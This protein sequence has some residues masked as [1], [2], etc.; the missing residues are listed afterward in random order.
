MIFRFSTIGLLLLFSLPAG[1]A[2]PLK[3]KWSEGEET[4][5]LMTQSMTMS[6]DAGGAG[7]I[8]STTH[9]QML[10]RWRV[11]EVRDEGDALITQSVDRIVMKTN[12]PMGQGFTYDSA[13]EDPPV[14]MGA[15]VA[16]MLDT[17]V[18]SDM[19]LTMAP[20]GEL[21]EVQLSEELAEAFKRVPGGSTSADMLEQMVKKMAFQFPDAPLTEGKSWTKMAT[22]R[23]P[24]MGKLEVETTYTYLGEKVIEGQ[25]LETF[26]VSETLRP[27]GRGQLEMEMTIATRESTGQILF[28]RET[29][30]LVR[31]RITQVM[32][33]VVTIDEKEVTNR[34]EQTVEMRELDQ[35]EEPVFDH[36]S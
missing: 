33:V 6:M 25:T 11:G 1:A 19:Q 15:M 8:E 3:W 26:S 17:L 24:Q 16:P 7:A 30:R 12:G 13:S 21:T 9:Q 23:A 27:V 18:E 14:G 31:S 2:E 28:N 10:L 36:A 32:D 4:R 5:Y 35:K 22:I 20:T 34:V 29:G